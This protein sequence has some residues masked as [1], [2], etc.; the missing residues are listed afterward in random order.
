MRKS[1]NTSSGTPPNALESR[2]AQ[3]Y[4][5]NVKHVPRFSLWMADV[6]GQLRR[7]GFAILRSHPTATLKA[8]RRNIINYFLPA[9]IGWPFGS[10]SEHANQFVLA[11]LLKPFDLILSGKPFKHNYA[12]VSYVSSL[13]VLWFGLWRLSRSVKR[14]LRERQ[15]NPSDLTIAFAFGNIAYLSAVVIFYDFT[16]QNRILFELFPLF[17]VLLGTLITL[18][19]RRFR[20]SRLWVRRA[21][22]RQNALISVR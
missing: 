3:R 9:D 16:D 17:A 8:I 10:G 1:E 18:A 15:I 22:A 19:M 6:G 20:L 21:R 2:D 5:R 7:D 4:A 13:C 12:L 14:A 11:P